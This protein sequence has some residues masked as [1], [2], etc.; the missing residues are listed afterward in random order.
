VNLVIVSRLQTYLRSKA[1]YDGR[2]WVRI[3]P[4]TLFFN[5]NVD[6][7]Y[8]GV[9]IPDEFQPIMGYPA[10]VVES[11]C[12][13]FEARARVPFVRFLDAFAPG[14]PIS[15]HLSGKG[16]RET[17]RLPVLACVPER[18]VHPP[19]VPGLTYV[20]VSNVSPLDDVKD[21]LD[22]N[23][24]GFDPEPTRAEDRTAEKFRGGLVDSF[25]FIARIE[26]SPV[27]AGMFTEIHDGMTELVGIT[28]LEA[29]RGK[30]IG[31]ALTAYMTRTA[32]E[33]GVEIAFLIAA[34]GDAQR[35]YQRIGYRV[36]ANLL[37]FEVAPVTD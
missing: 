2:E 37:E 28:T 16:F 22:V 19:D 25:A 27:A 13:A 8:E 1:L 6:H 4:F 31:A 5:P 24:R 23:S 9:A 11:L 17:S 12:E 32:F 3:P 10:E 14:L 34:T 36:V 21:S 7:A 15:L 30:G 26:G 29:Y 18:L 20:T 35:V 33:S